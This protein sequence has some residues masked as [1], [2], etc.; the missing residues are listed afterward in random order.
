[1]QHF[2]P[3]DLDL[4]ER[5]QV[6][7]AAMMGLQSCFS[8][9][10][11]SAFMALVAKRK[12]LEQDTG[13]APPDKKAPKRKAGKQPVDASTVPVKAEFPPLPPGVGA[14]LA[15]NLKYMATRKKDPNPAPLEEYQKLTTQAAKREWY[16]LRYKADPKCSF[17]SRI[18]NHTNVEESTAS[19]LTGWATKYAYAKLQGIENGMPDYEA[20]CDAA[21]EDMECRD[22]LNK[23]LAARGLKEY[24]VTHEALR[25]SKEI[26]RAESGFQGQAQIHDPKALADMA[27]TRGDSGSSGSQVTIA[28]WLEQYMA[29]RK[30]LES[31]LTKADRASDVAAADLNA[32]R[33][34]AV[35]NKLCETLAEELHQKIQ[36]FNVSI[37]AIVSK[38]QSMGKKNKEDECLADIPVMND[39]AGELDGHDVLFKEYMKKIRAFLK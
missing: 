33:R 30:N 34:Q 13:E 11:F 4:L 24:L 14:Q 17:V 29:A 26:E 3:V 36:T 39:M 27:L 28:P 20:L 7:L 2:V 8:F 9:L 19:T 22:H 5:A 16:W 10:A 1:M 18:E 23:G 25:E 12:V 38:S 21:V 15:S 37:Q 31:K 35:T 6:A 32:M